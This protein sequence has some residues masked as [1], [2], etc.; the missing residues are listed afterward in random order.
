M[1]NVQ[2][3][4]R[5]TSHRGNEN[6]WNSFEAYLQPKLPVPLRKAC[7]YIRLVSLGIDGWGCWPNLMYSR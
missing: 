4:A 1:S 2:H 7:V 6:M 3:C 5:I